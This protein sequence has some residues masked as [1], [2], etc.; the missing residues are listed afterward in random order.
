MQGGRD[1]VTP[2]SPFP[3]GVPGAEE[4]LQP[5]ACPVCNSYA[6]PNVETHNKMVEQALRDRLA[7][8]SPPEA[9]TC[10]CNAAGLLWKA[11]HEGCPAERPEDEQ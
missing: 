9:P 1:A 8:L 2:A 11:H 4:K 7:A 6:C 3:A 10:T 5:K